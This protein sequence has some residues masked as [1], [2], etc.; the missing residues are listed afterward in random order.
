MLKQR[1]DHAIEEKA[2]KHGIMG[3][4]VVNVSL[5]LAPDEIEEFHSINF[6]DHYTWEI[7]GNIVNIGWTEELQ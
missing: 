6:D 2:L 7:E 4:E 1:I 5:E 3:T